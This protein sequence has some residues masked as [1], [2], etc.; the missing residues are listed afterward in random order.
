V[1]FSFRPRVGIDHAFVQFGE[2]LETRGRFAERTR[3]EYRDDVAHLVEF[4]TASCHL[5]AIAAVER[6]HLVRYMDALTTAGQAA[7][8]RRRVVAAVRLFFRALAQEGVLPRSPA[9]LLL[10][11]PREDRPPR[12][13]T[14]DE[15]E[16]LRVGAEDRRAA[17]LIE[18]VLQTGLS[19]SEIARLMRN[20]VTLPLPATMPA[21][22][23][24]RIAGR[25]HRSRA[26]TLNTR[27]C[28]A[29]QGYLNERE[30]MG[31]AHLFLTKNSS[32]LGRRSVETIITKAC[33]AAGLRGI[34]VRTLRHTFAA[35]SLAKGTSV[36]T[37]QRSLGLASP[38]GV[39]GYV[40]AA[41]ALMDEQLQRN[42]L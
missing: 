30:D 18:L 39:E 20:D 1:A 36:E 40:E 7:N 4:L 29:L 14:Q 25:N 10:P 41:R 22:G 21:V 35:H 6:G 27:A 38:T 3:V 32:G 42:A 34:S 19:L 28:T 37:M 23:S 5:T 17:A 11:P 2:W 31:D 26:V 9:Q 24:V 13:L 15:Y 33:K 12:I 16:R 8:T